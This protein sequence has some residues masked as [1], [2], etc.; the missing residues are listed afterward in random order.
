MA[1][2]TYEDSTPQYFEPEDSGFDRFPITHIMRIG[3]VTENQPRK[4]GN[5]PKKDHHIY[6]ELS[7]LRT[8]VALS[9]T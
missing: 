5:K 2:T 4:V 7:A 9:G 6:Q 3:N 1:K 8:E